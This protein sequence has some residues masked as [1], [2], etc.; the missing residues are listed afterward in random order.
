MIET[1]KKLGWTLGIGIFLVFILLAVNQTIAF[2]ANL[3]TIHPV[4]AIVVTSILGLVLAAAFIS[5]VVLLLRLPKT[6]DFPDDESEVPAYRETMRKRLAKNSLVRAEGIDV[7]TPEG[8]EKAIHFLDSHARKVIQDTAASVFVTTA[9][10]QNGKLDALTVLVTQTRMVWKIA[11]IYWQRP[12]L[13]DMTTLY[14]NVAATA[15][16]A[17]ELEE[18][19]IS[20]Q[21]EPVINSLVNSPGRSI[22]VVGH[23]AHIIT[24]SLLEGSTNAFLTLRVGIVAQ[25]YCGKSEVLNRK[26]LRR[27]SFIEAS[28]MLRSIV[29]KSSGKVIS[30]VMKALKDAGKRSIL[31]G[32]GA[33]GKATT[34]VSSSVGDAMRSVAGK[35]RSSQLEE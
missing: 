17:S 29:V 18:M 5:P 21:I 10:S 35:K 13:R 31:S 3:S 32:I 19:D 1:L 8:Y 14:G 34:R 30:G 15:L 6:I 24:D 28:G 23:A 20:R 12:T 7:S 16:F 26:F 22:P 4:L 27:N 11:H 33:I 2:Y 9:I 25:K